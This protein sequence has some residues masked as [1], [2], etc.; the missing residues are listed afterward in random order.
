MIFVHLVK[1]DCLL[2]RRVQLIN[3]P[4][5]SILA[6]LFAK[7]VITSVEKETIEKALPLKSE[8][9]LDNIII[10][11]LANNVTVKF[12]AFLEVM[13]QSGD[14]LLMDMAKKL[15]MYLFML[16][17]MNTFQVLSVQQLKM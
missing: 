3:L 15:G 11:S 9:F 2:P 8:Y 16:I 13:E 14:P 7:D 6:K 10:P 17:F 12:K 1:L 4:I 5:E